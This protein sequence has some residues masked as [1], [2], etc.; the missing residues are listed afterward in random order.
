VD[1]TRDYARVSHSRQWSNYNVANAVLFFRLS[2]SSRDIL[3][4]FALFSVDGEGLGTVQNCRGDITSTGTDV[5]CRQMETAAVRLPRIFCPVRM[6]YSL[7]III[8]IK[9]KR[10]SAK[11]TNI[12][13]K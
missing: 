4:Y 7:K 3:V 12:P 8:V 2:F 1:N 9:D 11:A 6:Q 13:V 5:D 10:Q